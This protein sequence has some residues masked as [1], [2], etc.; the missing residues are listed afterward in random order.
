MCAK[1]VGKNLLLA[2]VYPD[3]LTIGEKRQRP[4]S[5]L[6]GGGLGDCARYKVA[7]LR[8]RSPAPIQ[9][10]ESFKFPRLQTLELRM[11]NPIAVRQHLSTKK[12]VTFFAADDLV[13]RDGPCC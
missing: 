7:Q 1:V 12:P 3:E 9:F 2:N 11:R 5:S 13:E 4:E 10:E 6:R 8:E